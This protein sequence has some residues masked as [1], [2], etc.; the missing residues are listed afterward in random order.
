MRIVIITILILFN[1]LGFTRDFNNKIQIKNDL[2]FNLTTNNKI[3]TIVYAALECSNLNNI[4]ITINQYKTKEYN[5]HVVGKDNNYYIFINTS[6]S[7]E[8]LIVVIAHETIHIKQ[9]FNKDLIINNNR[10]IY[11][12]GESFK[13]DHFYDVDNPW[14]IEAYKEQNELSD[15]IKLY[16]YNKNI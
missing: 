8:D 13:V 4:I 7:I 6:L 15:K 11:F 2:I 3:D 10:Y 5:G 12:K 1:F 16:L 9:L 14:E